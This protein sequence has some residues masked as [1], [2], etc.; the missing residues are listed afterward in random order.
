VSITV[1]VAALAVML[2]APAVA[3]DTAGQLNSRAVGERYHIEVATTLWSPN[4]AGDISSDALNLMG[5]HI[6][7]A[8]DLGF[9]RARAADIR[10]VFRP[11]KKH[12]FRAE[13][14]PVQYAADTTFSRIITF[15]GVPFP[16]SIPIHSTFGWRTWRFGYE[17]DFIYRKRGF[18]GV[19]FE[20]RQ[21]QLDASL[22]SLVVGGVTTGSAILPA[23]G[24]TGRAYVLPS[25]AV[26]FELSGLCAL[27]SRTGQF[28][29]RC[30][31]DAN[32]DYQATYFDWNI[33]GTINLNNYVGAQVG[34][35]R[36]TTNLNFGTDQGALKFQGLWF[37]GVVRY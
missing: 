11:G 6:D 37:G 31:Q 19:L 26:N 18:V 5:S 34:W 27:H 32:P 22:S 23:I 21:T 13:L 3:Q 1:F 2:A 16:V 30:T 17:Y 35:R 10:I 12:R 25:V 9:G 15:A 14:T 24:V 28:A 8:K 29:A 33:Y 7:F 4:L 20:A 36:Q